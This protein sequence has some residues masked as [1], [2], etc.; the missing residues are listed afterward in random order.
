MWVTEDK[1]RDFYEQEKKVSGVMWT[2]RYNSKGILNLILNINL[3]LLLH[4]ICNQTAVRLFI[5]SVPA[6]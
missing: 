5:C 6:S 1:V 3:F 4:F 2:L